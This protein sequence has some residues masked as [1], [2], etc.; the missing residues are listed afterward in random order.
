M[1]CN[2]LTL[3]GNFGH[4]LVFVLWTRLRVSCNAYVDPLFEIPS[5]L[6]A[7]NPTT[8]DRRILYYCLMTEVDGLLGGSMVFSSAGCH[9]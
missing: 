7:I 8:N 4:K 2:N 6:P 5:D 1:V 3:R 9:S